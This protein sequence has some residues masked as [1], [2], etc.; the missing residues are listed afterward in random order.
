MTSYHASMINMFSQLAECFTD[1]SG[2][3]GNPQIE[4]G[5]L[6]KTPLHTLF[7]G[8]IKAIE[9]GSPLHT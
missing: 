6:A 9:T 4:L 5:S 3:V 8:S 2:R 7:A 1:C